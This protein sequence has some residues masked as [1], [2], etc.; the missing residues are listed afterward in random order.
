MRG[1][2]VWLKDVCERTA[3]TFSCPT[4]QAN[5][6]R[7]RAVSTSDIAD[8]ACNK[9]KYTARWPLQHTT[10]SD[11]YRLHTHAIPHYFMFTFFA[12]VITAGSLR[13][14]IQSQLLVSCMLYF[15]TLRERSIAWC[16]RL[17]VMQVY[18]TMLYILPSNTPASVR[19]CWL[20]DRVIDW[21]VLFLG[22][23]VTS[24]TPTCD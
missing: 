13:I 19:A 8:Y 4:T 23:T 18:H 1:C 21:R 2:A 9:N 3:G 20:V 16:D 11:A 5:L 10:F 15:L 12:Y 22:S 7:R 6:I 24:S 17:H 14:V